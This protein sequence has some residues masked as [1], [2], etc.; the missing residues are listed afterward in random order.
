MRDA[1]LLTAA[2]GTR[3]RRRAA[4]T[5]SPRSLR[6]VRALEPR[7]SCA[8]SRRSGR[9]SST[10]G[11]PTRP[12]RA[13]CSRS[14][15]CGSRAATRGRR[16]R[17]SPSASSGSSAAHRA[18]PTGPLLR[19]RPRRVP[20]ADVRRPRP[21]RTRA[22]STRRR[23]A[24]PSSAQQP[25]YAEVEAGSRG[26]RS[27]QPPPPVERG[28]DHR[29]PRAASATAPI[30]L[31][32]VIVAWADDP[33]GSR[34]PHACA[35]SEAQP[36]ALDDDVITFGVPERVRV[37]AAGGSRRKPT[38]IRPRS[39]QR[40]GRR[41]SSSSS[42]GRRTSAALPHRPRLESEPSPDRQ[43]RE[44]SAEPCSARSPTTRKFIDLSELTD[45]APAGSAVDSSGPARRSQ[46]GRDRRR[47]AAPRLASPAKGRRRTDG[48]SASSR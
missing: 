9:P 47:R 6:S 36:I 28:A 25:P 15:S 14:R 20:P 18:A 4:K 3:A 48:Q 17:R 19:R 37:A 27:R 31:D 46:F 44:R 41:C 32:D 10:C 21:H 39:P 2:K 38:T 13:S 5:T 24:A 40:L 1:F 26:R 45:V 33:P 22:R 34:R 12:I 8:S 42:R 23:Q 29:E 43:W 30:D 35:A 16:C 7:S 11:V